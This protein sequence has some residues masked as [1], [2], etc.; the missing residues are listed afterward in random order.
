M[1]V[2]FINLPAQFQEIKSEILS[3][4]VN[5]LENANFTLGPKVASFE[6]DF[7]SFCN[8]NYAVG[9][10]SGTDAL[11]FAL[12][13]LNVK[14]GDEVILPAHTFVAT[15]EAVLH[16]GATPVLVDVDP[17]SYTMDPQKIVEKITRKTK[18]IIPVHLYGQMA[19]M[20][21]IAKIA[22]EYNLQVVED[23]CQ[24]HGAL[25][26]GKSAGSI[27]NIGCFSFYPGKNLGAY[28]DGGA[29]ITNNIEIARK[30]RLLRDHGSEEKYVHELVGYTSRL[31]ALQ[32]AI[33]SVKLRHLAE[34]NS[35]RIAIAQNY[36]EL[37]SEVPELKV[38]FVPSYNKHVFHLYVV[39]V[40]QR[41]KVINYLK[42]EGIQTMIHYPTPLHLQKAYTNLGYKKG[43]F[44]VSEALCNKV[45]SIPIYPELTE[46]QVSYVCDSLCEALKV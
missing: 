23:A 5:V 9:V 37:L 46:Q 12:R 8:V 10:N 39:Q 20:D 14:A 4:I 43:D 27:G 42:S 31:H 30:I 33:L 32:A 21:A 22:Q 16:C 17:E 24:A 25:Y 35:K 1:Q 38:P 7:A 29:C 40:E 36:S 6:K 28:G 15:V 2:P 18:A 19:D 45:V 44:P 26:K 41:N 13:A 3:E 11:H 34:W